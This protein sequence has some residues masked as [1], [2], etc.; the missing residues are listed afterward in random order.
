MRAS[1][2]RLPGGRVL[3]QDAGSDEQVDYRSVQLL[4]VGGGRGRLGGYD[5]VPAK[6]RGKH[7]Y[8]FA[9]AAAQA[10]ADNGAAQPLWRDEPV[11]GVFERVGER[12]SHEQLV[13]PG[14]ASAER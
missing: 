9:E 8:R 2:G 4:E 3:C 7:A 1:R 14:A 13:V 5:D 6:T 11:A 12:P 10:V